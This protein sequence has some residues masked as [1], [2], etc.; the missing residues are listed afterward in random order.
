VRSRYGDEIADLL[1]DSTRPVRDLAD[2]AR[3]ALIDRVTTR[4]P[5]PSRPL[6][7]VKLLLVPIGIQLLNL[8]PLTPLLAGSVAL[9]F[10][11]EATWLLSGM[12]AGFVAVLVFWWARRAGRRW[13]I[14]SRGVVV[15]IIMAVGTL[16]WWFIP[17]FFSPN[18]RFIPLILSVAGPSL[19]TWCLGLILLNAAIG[20]LSKRVSGWAA[21]LV[22]AVGG[23]T[24]M[25]LCTIVH[26]FAVLEP[27]IAPV[28]NP[29][30]WYP[31]RLVGYS[32]GNAF[33]FNSTIND[34][35]QTQEILLTLCTVFALTLIAASRTSVRRE[36]V[37]VAA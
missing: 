23:F 33:G 13:A 6:T 11:V 15:P 8:V 20:R 21:G 7:I 12:L 30:L 31:V 4:T 2:V 26:M 10:S 28:R 22:I 9:K 17:A 18:F 34:V 35:A 24:V 37:T 29:M 14:A 19:A 5:S 16:C 25:Q 1:A 3:C 32:T 36:V 27:Q